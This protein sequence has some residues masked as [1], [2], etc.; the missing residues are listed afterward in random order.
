MGKGKRNRFK[1]ATN[2]NKTGYN[3]RGYPVPPIYGRI[4]LGSGPVVVGALVSASDAFRPSEPVGR[5]EAGEL[6]GGEGL[7]ALDEI[8]DAG[9]AKELL[10]GALGSAASTINEALNTARFEP[11]LK[12]DI[13]T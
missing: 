11:I 9:L 3:K 13:K 2:G 1:R 4:G 5:M 12:L 7:V 6:D 8:T 10:L